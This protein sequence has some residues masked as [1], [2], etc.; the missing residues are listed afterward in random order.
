MQNKMQ[1][2]QTGFTIVELLI[3][4]VVIGILA[5]ITIVAYNGVQSKAKN[6]Q[7]VAAVRAY[8]TAIASYGAENGSYPTGNACLGSSDF[9]VSNPC[10]IGANTY[11]YNAALNDALSKYMGNSVPSLPSLKVSNGSITGSG[12]FYYS[13]G[14]Y[15]GFPMSSTK[16]CPTIAGA[17]IRTTGV[18]GSDVYCT[19]N[20]PTI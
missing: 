12:I 9:Y 15:I 19:I 2:K 16:E 13:A 14:S 6:N 20:F 7:T 5:A 1:R 17:T 18:I 8:Y 4:I 3:V 10:Y 11:I